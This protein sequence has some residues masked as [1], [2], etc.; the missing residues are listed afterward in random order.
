MH[1]ELVDGQYVYSENERQF[2]HPPERQTAKELGQSVDTFIRLKNN[3]KARSDH[4]MESDIS[5]DS[6]LWQLYYLNR[7]DISR[8][9]VYDIMHVANLNLFKNFM[10]KFFQDICEHPKSDALLELV[11]ATCTSITEVCTYELKQGQW[12]QD[13]IN[14]HESYT[15]DEC[16]LFVMWVLPI[17]L[18]K[19]E[20]S[21]YKYSS[22]RCIIGHLLVDI[23]H[24]FFNW[25]RLKGWSIED[26]H[27]VQQLLKK[28]RNLS[29]ALDG[30]NGSMW[31]VLPT[32]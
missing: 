8:D 11:E 23:A 32:F 22:R 1:S 14:D 21:K 4:S 2:E 30:P 9:L 16:Q 19:L 18:N 25:T 27:I 31:Q 6:K 17:I 13:P 7:F 24:I 10:I 3:K 15:T 26:L 29:E 12:P 28:W 5:G 20:A